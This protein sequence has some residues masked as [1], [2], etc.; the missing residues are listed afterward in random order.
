L[1][2]SQVHFSSQN[3]LVGICSEKQSSISR[4]YENS[5]KSP[6]NP[7]VVSLNANENPQKN[8]CTK[9]VVLKSQER[10][11]RETN[12]KR[13]DCYRHYT[14]IYHRKRIF[15]PQKARVE[16]TDAWNHY[17]DEGH[18]CQYPCEIALIVNV[19]LAI[20]VCCNEASSYQRGEIC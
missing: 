17:P 3:I 12:L 4:W 9:S 13:D 10:R 6:I 16:E 14:K 20:T 8:H 2:V 5:R 18:R 11:R 19:A 15:S 7:F 1:R